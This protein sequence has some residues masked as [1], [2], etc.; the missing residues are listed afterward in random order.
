MYSFLSGGDSYSINSTRLTLSSFPFDSI[1]CPEEILTVALRDILGCSL[2]NLLIE[3]KDETK[4]SITLGAAVL[5]SKI[6][7]ESKYD[8]SSS[9]S[10]TSSISVESDSNCI[11]ILLNL[12]NRKLFFYLLIIYQKINNDDGR[13]IPCHMDELIKLSVA[14]NIPIYISKKLFQVAARDATLEKSSGDEL[15]IKS[16]MV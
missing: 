1:Q 6:G 9:S 11:Y 15:I 12:L 4:Q 10:T 8:L 16:V 5:L 7:M 3:V 14:L 13:V 2:L